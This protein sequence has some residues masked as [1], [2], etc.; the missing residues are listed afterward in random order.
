MSGTVPEAVNRFYQV[1]N[2]HDPNLWEKAM[3]PNYVG[4]VNTDNIP[5]RDVGKGFVVGLLQA[6]PD[7]CY[8][9]EDSLREGN[10]VVARWSATGTHTGNLFGMPPTNKKVKMIGITI[11]RIEN[12]QIAEL[13]DV[14]DQGGM[15]A[16]LNS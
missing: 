2:E 4:H 14:W 9:V 5:S 13:W 10:R 12:D 16:Q 8:T 3:A 1:Y 7:I 11:F 6:F 15:M